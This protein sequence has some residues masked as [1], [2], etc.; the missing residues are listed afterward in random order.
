MSRGIQQILL[1]TGVGCIQRRR[2]G[3][4]SAS[5]CVRAGDMVRFHARH[6]LLWRTRRRAARIDHGITSNARTTSFYR[7]NSTP[8]IHPSLSD[9]SQSQAFISSFIINTY[10]NYGLDF[11]SAHCYAHTAKKRQF[12]FTYIFCMAVMLA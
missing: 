6:P 5:R 4:G 12:F 1:R 9:Q 11:G 2:R 7:P 3:L 8:K 10:Y